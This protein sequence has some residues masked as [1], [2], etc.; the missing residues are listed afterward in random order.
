[1]LSQANLES[2]EQQEYQYIMG[3]PLRKLKQVR[4]KVLATPGRYSYLR[5]KHVELDGRR[6][7]LCQ[8]PKEEARDAALREAFLQ[9]LEAEVTYL[10][11]KQDTQKYRDVLAHCA[12]TAA[13]P[14]RKPVMT[15]SMCCAPTQNSQEQKWQRIIA[16]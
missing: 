5:I 11:G 2:L 16:P 10:A 1:M 15:V 3:T 6:Y 8:N 4:E 12:S 13:K 7:I 14:D 9:S